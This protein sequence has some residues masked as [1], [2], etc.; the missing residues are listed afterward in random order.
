MSMNKR[1]RIFLIQRVGAV[2]I[3]LD[4]TNYV[5]L[6]AV[7]LVFFAT[8]ELFAIYLLPTDEV[9][10][11]GTNAIRS[12]RMATSG[13]FAMHT[14]QHPVAVAQCV[15]LARQRNAFVFRR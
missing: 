5:L 12:I 2:A 13:T 3:I 7:C 11:R 9:S 4:T 1:L 6:V 10:R 8:D 14:L 15:S